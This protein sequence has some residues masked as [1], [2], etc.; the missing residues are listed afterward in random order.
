MSEV[1]AHE[2]ARV[3]SQ[4]S[5]GDSMDTALAF[6]GDGDGCALT[7]D[8]RPA[9]RYIESL[10][11]GTRWISIS[12]AV[13]VASRVESVEAADSPCPI[14]VFDNYSKKP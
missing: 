3:P 14:T 4:P 7:V 13:V 2:R 1:L 12:V 5:F 10:Y 8:T 6:L 9:P 11:H